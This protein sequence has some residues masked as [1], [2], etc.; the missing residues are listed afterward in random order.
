MRLPHDARLPDLRTVGAE[1]TD[2]ALVPFLARVTRWLGGGAD[3]L[4]SEFGLP[5]ADLAEE[6]VRGRRSSPRRPRRE[7]IGRVLD[8]LRGAGATGAMLWCYADY[9]AATFGRPPMDE[10]THER[11]FGLWRADGTP[12]PAVDVVRAFAGSTRS[13]PPRRPGSTS[14]PDRYWQRPGAELPRLY[15]PLQGD[16]TGPA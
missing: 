4:F 8:G 15:E 14:T 11:S 2:A 12:K 13:A 16:A 7:Y 3:V 9:D 10:A 1:P 6:A 5:T